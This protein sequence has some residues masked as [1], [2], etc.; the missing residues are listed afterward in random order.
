MQKIKLK[1]TNTF[2][3]RSDHMRKLEKIAWNT[4]KNTGDIQTFLELKQVENV[5][6]NLNGVSNEPIKNEGNCIGRE[7]SGRL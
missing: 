1:V 7:Q 4:F 6:N 5:E 2:K 3:L